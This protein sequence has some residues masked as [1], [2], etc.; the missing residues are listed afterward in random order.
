MTD[1]RCTENGKAVDGVVTLLAT[2]FHHNDLSLDL[3]SMRRQVDFVL[4]AGVSAVVACGKAGEYEGMTLDEVERVLTMVLEHVDGRVPVGM[5][6]ISVELERGLESAEIARRCGADF[7]MVK[8]KSMKGLAK[9]FTEIADRIPVMLYDQTNEGNL[10]VD[11]QILPLVKQCERIVT[12]KVSGNVY[13]IGHL[14]EEIADVSL[15]CGWDIFSLLAYASGADGVVAGSAAFMPEREVEL[16]RLAQAER[17]DEARALFYD[18]MLPYI[19]FA[20]HDPY[21]FSVAKY[22]LY[23][24]EIIDSPKTRPPYANAPDWMLDELR[25]LAERLELIG[26]EARRPS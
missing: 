19:V 20:T 3:D 11:Q 2:P 4:N 6:I 21:A 15:I 12:V 10:S 17:W 8:K 26:A 18:R 25:V 24:R 5:G 13:S 9:F 7:A 22:L 16:H 23:L 14:K 1:R